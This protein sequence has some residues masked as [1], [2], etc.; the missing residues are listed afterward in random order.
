[1]EE[2]FPEP[3]HRITSILIGGTFI[4]IASVVMEALAGW[5]VGEIVQSLVAP[6]IILGIALV[7]KKARKKASDP[8]WITALAHFL[9]DRL[10][11]QMS[12]HHAVRPEAP[13]PGPEP[14]PERITDGQGNEFINGVWR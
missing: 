10:V 14:N 7:R 6:A 2:N 1:M 4:V 8:L 13:N 5:S 11:A 12:K 9:H 3:V